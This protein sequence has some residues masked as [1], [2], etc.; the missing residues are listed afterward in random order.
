[1][2]TSKVILVSGSNSGFGRLTVETLAR[3]GHT[4]FAGIRNSG[5]K[6]AVAA[7]ELRALAQA[8]Q[9]GLHVVDLN[10]T[11]DISVEQAVQTVISTAGRIDVVV[12]NAGVGGFGPIE[13]YTPDQV[14]QMFDTNLVGVVRLNRAA[15]PYM[16]AQ[17][18]G[19]L[20][21]LGSIVGRI[22]Y[23]FTGIYAASKFALEGLTEAYRLELAALG[24][25]AVIVEPGLYPTNIVANMI[26][27][28]D[29]DRALP[30]QTFL[31]QTFAGVEASVSGQAGPVPNPQEV[32]DTI[33]H[34]IATPAGQRPLRTVVGLDGQREGPLTLNAASD[35]VI[36]ATGRAFGWEPFTTG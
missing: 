25:D 29:A 13:A 9:L 4:V 24:V 16:R 19:L 3:Q 22:A 11:D 10:V 14:R 20:I 5:A 23:P 27:P 8:E 17:S 31:T 6:N 33:A 36:Q 2:N 28:G 12:N 34:L 15:L 18:S 7:Q 26:A 32:A 35:Q 1:M 21:Q 30:Y